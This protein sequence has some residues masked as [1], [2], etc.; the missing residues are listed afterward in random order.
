[1]RI[2][3]LF[4]AEHAINQILK[5]ISD[6]KYSLSNIKQ[7]GNQVV[8]GGDT[9][10]QGKTETRLPNILALSS[11]TEPTDADATGAFV[12]EP[13]YEFDGKTYNVGNVKDGVL[14]A[15]FSDD[16]G[17]TANEGE[18]GGFVIG[19]DTLESAN[20]V[21]D[22]AGVKLTGST[23]LVEANNAKIGGFAIDNNTIQSDNYVADTAGVKLTASTGMVEANNAKIGGW[24][25]DNTK[26]ESQ[27]YTAGQS[28]A[29]LNGLTGDIEVNNIKARGTIV[30]SVFEKGQVTATSGTFGVF[31]SAGKLKASVTTAATFNIDIDDPE[32]GHAAL[33]AADDILRIKDGSGDNWA[34]VD[35]VSDQTTFY[36]YTCTLESG[37]AAT[38]TPGTI[39]L[40]YGQ[41]NDGFLWMTADQ[42]N[43]PYYGVYVH[44]GDPWNTV[45]EVARLGNL[46]GALDYVTNAYGVAIGDLNGYLRYDPAGGFRIGFGSDSIV[47]T[48]AGFG[49]TGETL[50]Y[51]HTVELDSGET[52]RLRMGVFRHPNNDRYLVSGFKHDG[53]FPEYSFDG[54]VMV[55]ELLGTNRGW[56]DET[57]A[58]FTLSITG[59]ESLVL[60]TATPYEGTYMRR[61]NVLV[62]EEASGDTG[63]INI[64]TQKVAATEGLTYGFS[65][66]LRKIYSDT[67]YAKTVTHY[68]RANFYTAA[69][70]LISYQTITN[71]ILQSTAWFTASGSY[72]APVGTAQV[73][74]QVYCYLDKGATNGDARITFDCDLF[75]IQGEAYVGTGGSWG[76]T[77][78]QNEF[79]LQKWMHF[80]DQDETLYKVFAIPQGIPAPGAPTATVSAT[81]GSVDVGTHSYKV[82]F[83]DDYGETA[84]GT[85]S[86]Q[87]TVATSGKLVN[88]TAVP[89]SLDGVVRTRKIYRTKAGDNG[90]YY[91]V[92]EIMDNTTLT[93][94]DDIADNALGELCSIKN[95]TGS[96]KMYPE[97]WLGTFAEF[98]SFQAGGTFFNAVTTAYSTSTASG[99]MLN[100]VTATANNGDFFT[101]RFQ[102]AAG[103]Y[104]LNVNVS[105]TTNRGKVDVYIDNVKVNS[106]TLDLYADILA[107]ANWQVTNIVIAKSGIH[108]IKFVV[109]GKNASSTDYIMA[110]GLMTM[111]PWITVTP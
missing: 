94:D 38:F 85:A 39:V 95:T 1:M 7:L 37:S 79:F 2:K 72:V 67:M 48:D 86:S 63:Y 4:D 55:T 88:L 91:L 61:G 5:T 89:K 109:N 74:L 21:A 14:G 80:L 90:E 43:A 107:Q 8:I 17:I 25:V 54:T 13:G 44:A 78:R 101:C 81:E 36:R 110:M 51:T 9:T 58:Q 46:N 52:S 33:F 42:T 102:I 70:T 103:K 19:A 100:N 26:I 29:T 68:V 82:T 106:T 24:E 49:V 12:A 3:N 73:D 96:D 50:G 111:T 99:S 56:E 57:T 92:G 64:H 83:V 11:G 65:V 45:N 104:V 18:V 23:G 53:L 40:D 10:F 32:S 66:K 6:L 28:G 16:G 60:S 34:T 27:N 77:Q 97:Y 105:K 93:F 35:S 62:N 108:E 15:G 20:Y 22:T 76:V 31:K 98:K 87:I 59:G 69:G 75:S 41:A 84:G 47:L 71:N 30:A